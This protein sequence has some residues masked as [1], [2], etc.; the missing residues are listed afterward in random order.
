MMEERKEGKKTSLFSNSF[1]KCGKL[2]KDSV[3]TNDYTKTNYNK[4]C[5]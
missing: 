1:R 5:F 4:K 2:E 3:S